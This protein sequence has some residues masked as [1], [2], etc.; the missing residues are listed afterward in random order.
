MGTQLLY[1]S[2]PG[3]ISRCA[4]GKL[5]THHL[6][7]EWHSRPMLSRPKK[8]LVLRNQGFFCEWPTAS[9]DNMRRLRSR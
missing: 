5:F 2:P 4:H 9:L 3:G 7:L 1:T 6:N 8:S